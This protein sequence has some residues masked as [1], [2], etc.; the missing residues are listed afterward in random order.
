MTHLG[1]IALR[2]TPSR[3]MTRSFRRP[4]LKPYGFEFANKVGD[5]NGMILP[6]VGSADSLRIKE[7]PLIAAWQ[8][9]PTGSNLPT[10]LATLT[11]FEPVLLP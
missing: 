8:S 9:N 2:V 3:D 11:G 5:P 1:F 6:A 10:E 4:R 7:M